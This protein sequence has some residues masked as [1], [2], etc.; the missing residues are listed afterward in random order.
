MQANKKQSF[1]KGIDYLKIYF[2]YLFTEVYFTTIFKDKLRK[3][4]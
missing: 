2:I 3:L 1:N 4:F